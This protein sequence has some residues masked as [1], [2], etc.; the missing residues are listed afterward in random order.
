ML[1]A[2]VLGIVLVRS[3][4]PSCMMQPGTVLVTVM[5]LGA[6]G[7]SFG[8]PT[9][10]EITIYQDGLAHVTTQAVADTEE[11]TLIIRLLGLA[12]DNFVAI[13]EDGVLL[14]AERVGID[15]MKLETF[16]SDQVDISYD[17]HD[18]VSKDGRIWTFS[19]DIDHDYTILMP[20]DSIIIGMDAIPRNLDTINDKVRL[21]MSDGPVEISYI[22]NTA[23]NLEP[24]VAS[25]PEPN[26][27]ANVLLLILIPIAAVGAFVFIRARSRK[28]SVDAG[29]L[30]GD[31]VHIDADVV[32]AK[33]PD[34]RDEDQEIVR[35]ICESGGE[36]SESNLRKKFLRPKTSIWRAVQRLSREGVVDITKVD[37]QNHI[38][39]RQEGGE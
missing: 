24:P 32:L 11:P 33:V 21:E 7:T 34:L 36:V 29:P 12:V 15:N 1:P 25:P 10:T 3:N 14:V 5:V 23:H 8:A 6:A 16:G 19:L 22:T 18:I 30:H 37:S 38:R 2:S 27:D 39:I 26:E 28:K 20:S 13:N 4:P 31:I 17:T 35:Y 9:Y